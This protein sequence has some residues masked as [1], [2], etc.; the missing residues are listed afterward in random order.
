M[1]FVAQMLDGSLSFSSSLGFLTAILDP[2]LTLQ[3]LERGSV[4]AELSF[5]GWPQR[6]TAIHLQRLGP[7]FVLV[8]ALAVLHTLMGTSHSQTEL[9]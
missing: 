8:A 6:N 5:Q 9:M 7:T 4:W 3:V 2:L 1:L